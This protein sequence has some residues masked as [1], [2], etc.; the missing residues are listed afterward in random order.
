MERGVPLSG[1]WLD[2][3]SLHFHSDTGRFL[4]LLPETVSMI[5]ES[6][7]TVTMDLGLE[8]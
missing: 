3:P 8:G 1:P 7:R 4:I 6:D 5:N 2:V